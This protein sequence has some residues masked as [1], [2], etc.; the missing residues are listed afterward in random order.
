V[1][2]RVLLPL[3]A[4]LLAAVLAG[5]APLGS[6][7]GHPSMPRGSATSTAAPQ[8]SGTPVS[9]VHPTIGPAGCTITSPG[10]YQV[11]DCPILQVDVDGATVTAGR[12][13]TIAI[14]GDRDQVLA[15][16]GASV[17]IAGQ[18]DQVVVAGD[19]GGIDIRG[20]RDE[21]DG[22][23]R[24]GSGRIAGNDDTVTAAAGVGDITDDGARNT[25]G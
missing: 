15:D 11:A 23:G 7:L 4:V 20:D 6:V 8:P 5:C 10:A 17:H 18:D 12:I 24:I 13:G 9:P 21:I 2:R 1:T 25:I 3:T 16:A 22:R 19:I 14:N